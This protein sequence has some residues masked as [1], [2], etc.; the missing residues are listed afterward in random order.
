MTWIR[1]SEE[2]QTTVDYVDQ[3]LHEARFSLA[4]LE[5]DAEE[6]RVTLIVEQLHTAKLDAERVMLSCWRA[7]TPVHR[8]RIEFRDV[9]EFQIEDTARMEIYEVDGLFYAGDELILEATPTCYVKLRCSTFRASVDVSEAAIS[10]RSYYRFSRGRP[11][12]L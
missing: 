11:S 3:L 12:S 8:F 2:S 7:T 4:G 1:V 5:Y 6:R 9:L 10:Y